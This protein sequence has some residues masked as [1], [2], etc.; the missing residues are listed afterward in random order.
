MIAQGTPD[1]SNLPAGAG[2]RNTTDKS[3]DIYGSKIL[4]W[5]KKA[6][7]AGQSQVIAIGSTAKLVANFVSGGANQDI[8]DTLQA[9]CEESKYMYVKLTGKPIENLIPGGITIPLEAQGACCGTCGSTCTL[10]TD[11][12]IRDQFINQLLSYNLLGMSSNAI[13]AKDTG[14][15]GY[16]GNGTRLFR[17]P[18]V[19]DYTTIPGIAGNGSTTGMFMTTAARADATHPQINSTLS[20]MTN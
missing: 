6:Y 8:C 15:K 13:N 14:T 4:S 17:L 18:T 19:N 3:K 7:S 16:K 12:S 9:K 20:G 11:S 1:Q 5:R 2:I 10:S